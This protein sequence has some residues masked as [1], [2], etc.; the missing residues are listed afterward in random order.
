MAN[1]GD[2]RSALAL[3]SKKAVQLS[4]DHKPESET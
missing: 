3:K 2:S 1:I 4:Y